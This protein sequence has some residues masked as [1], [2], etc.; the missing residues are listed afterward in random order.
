M[1]SRRL[2][3]CLL[4]FAAIGC[5]TIIAAEDSPEPA[6]APA[7]TEEQKPAEAP[8]PASA[9]KPPEAPKPTDFP[10][11][12]VTVLD[13]SWKS[14]YVWENYNK[15]ECLW[16]AKVKNNNPEP[17]H[18]CLNYEFLDEDNLPVF[19]NGKCEVVLGNSEGI[20]KGSI[21]VT[22]RLVEDVKKSNVIALEAHPLHSFVPA[23]PVK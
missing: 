4:T 8:K 12:K 2:I 5:S 10:K 13:Y 15:T 17:R 11:I 14:G 18:I 7:A 20:I 9:P 21:M 23:P 19:Q 1:T 6:K 3:V 22:S 16:T